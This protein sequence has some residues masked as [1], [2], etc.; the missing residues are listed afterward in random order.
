VPFGNAVNYLSRQRPVGPLADVASTR[1]SNGLHVEIK[2]AP[3]LVEKILHLYLQ[4]FYCIFQ[5]TLQSADTKTTTT[6]RTVHK[7]FEVGTDETTLTF[8]S[9]KIKCH[10]HEIVCIFETTN[11]RLS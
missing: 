4:M 8:F 11:A 5:M 1:K 6:K 3:R 2:P 10:G 7:N 9:L